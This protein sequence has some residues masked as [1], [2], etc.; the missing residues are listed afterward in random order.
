MAS[1]Y[2]PSDKVFDTGNPQRDVALSMAV[3]KSMALA[4]KYGTDHEVSGLLQEMT[5]HLVIL[6]TMIKE[7]RRQAIERA[8]VLT[9]QIAEAE[10][11]IQSSPV[12]SVESRI[13]E[14]LR[15]SP[16]PEEIRDAMR[17]TGIGIGD[18]WQDVEEMEQDDDSPNAA[19][20]KA[21][22]D[23]TGI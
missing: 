21:A 6:G 15:H 22:R 16:T 11:V 12:R 3:R 18:G 19:E 9:K 2:N 1:N 20:I 8:A 23:R 10:A 4:K 7:Q 14:L 13:A 5:Q 17:R